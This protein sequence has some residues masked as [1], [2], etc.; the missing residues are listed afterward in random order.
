[1][2]AGCGSPYFLKLATPNPPGILPCAVHSAFRFLASC[3]GGARPVGVFRA[4]GEQG[5]LAN[6]A[7]FCFFC[8][9]DSGISDSDS[10]AGGA[11]GKG[12]VLSRVVG[13]CFWL[14]SISG[15]KKLIACLQSQAYFSVVEPNPKTEAKE[16]KDFEKSRG[17]NRILCFSISLQQNWIFILQS[18]RAGESLLL[19]FTLRVECVFHK[20]TWSCPCRLLPP[21]SAALSNLL[22]EGSTGLR[23]G[24]GCFYPESEKPGEE[25]LLHRPPGCV[26]ACPARLRGT[27]ALCVTVWI[28]QVSRVG[29]WR[30]RGFTSQQCLDLFLWSRLHERWSF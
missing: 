20:L 26:T 5:A 12:L 24:E 3:A 17:S 1:M 9:E 23:C 18:R 25:E 21:P 16:W 7:G 13:C 29:G 28:L 11:D 19:N 2:G 10:A 30:V 27:W 6:A 14:F 8:P 15:T 4:T 22:P